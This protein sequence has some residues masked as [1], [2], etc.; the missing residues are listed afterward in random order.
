MK[1]ANIMKRTKHLAFAI[2]LTFLA[3]LIWSAQA[4]VMPP[5]KT[6]TLQGIEISPGIEEKEGIYGIS[7]LGR[8]SGRLPG[9]FFMSLNY[10]RSSGAFGISP[11]QP[12]SLL[13]TIT[14]GTWSLPVYVYNRYVGAIYGHVDSGTMEWND[15]SKSGAAV[16]IVL[17]VDGGT[18]AF[19]GTSGKGRFS[20]TL[21]RITKDKPEMN[22][23]LEF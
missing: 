8:T 12:I 5:S 10:T 3:G 7:Y 4:Q 21:N 16:D 6:T 9:S 22:G 11:P 19:A 23:T 2:V 15:F 14:G 1:G 13:D 17:I 20:G 18:K